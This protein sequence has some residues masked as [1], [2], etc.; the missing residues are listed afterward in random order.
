MASHAFGGGELLHCNKTKL[1]LLMEIHNWP[2]A[3]L[4]GLNMS[5]RA[6]TIRWFKIV[7]PSTTSRVSELHFT[8]PPPPIHI[9]ACA[10]IVHSRL[11]LWIH[12]LSSNTA[13]PQTLRTV[14]SGHVNTKIWSELRTQTHPGRSFNM[15]N[16]WPPP[17]HRQFHSQYPGA[18]K[19]GII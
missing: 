10:R 9:H 4:T 2:C 8:S 12:T 14:H 7:P 5:A 18:H 19:I 15:E 17:A 16:P 13:S 1:K 6:E 11:D 3:S